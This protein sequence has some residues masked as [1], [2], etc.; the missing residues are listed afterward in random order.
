[1]YLLHIYIR[2]RAPASAQNAL[3]ISCERAELKCA[4]VSGCPCNRN[5]LL[6]AFTYVRGIQL[7]LRKLYHVCGAFRLVMCARLE[8][9]G[10]NDIDG[11]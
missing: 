5:I 6:C 7:A 10:E 3:E 1:M 4:E 8:K 2:G 11:I 9:T